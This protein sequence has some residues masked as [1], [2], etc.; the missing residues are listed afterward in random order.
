[1]EKQKVIA[2][3]IA[4]AGVADYQAMKVDEGSFVNIMNKI[5][6]GDIDSSEK[7]KLTRNIN[8]PDELSIVSI[9]SSVLLDNE[10]MELSKNTLQYQSLLALKK[11]YSDIIY[12]AIKGGKSA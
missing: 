6:E 5:Y 8:V 7:E 2:N 11:G 4:N 1:M 12:S 3:N 10:M 9:D